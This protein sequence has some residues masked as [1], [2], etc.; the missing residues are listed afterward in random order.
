MQ[1]I[2]YFIL[3]IIIFGIIVYYNKKIIKITQEWKRVTQLQQEQKIEEI[4]ATEKEKIEMQVR[5][6]TKELLIQKEKI[7]EIIKDKTEY[8]E[9]LVGQIRSINDSLNE[10]RERA[11]VYEEQLRED[12]KQ[13][14]DLYE[15]DLMKLIETKASDY[16][17]EK[18]KIAEQVISERIAIMDMQADRAQARI[19]I[20]TKEIEEYSAKQ[21]AI[22]NAILRQRELEEQ[23]NFYRVCLSDEAIMDITELQI[24]R[25]KL[26]KPEIL[27]KIIYD[28]YVAKPVLEMVKRVLQNSTCSG[29]YKITCQETK[30]IYIG[31]STD[32]K[33][34]WQQHCKTAFNCGTIASSLLHRKMQQY[35]IEN[36]TFELLETVS[37]DK[38]SE[39]ES[40]Y[41]DFYQSKKVGLNERRG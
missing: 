26:K 19:E 5:H 22:N 39:R 9:S 34:R 32:I 27:D 28:T 13:R 36:F 14:T 11:K 25:Q 18:F 10:Q 8:V 17:Q 30:E 7:E 16:E 23:Q 3:L 21:A 12:A 40:F 1:Y 31:K 29:I 35:G 33:N 15:S 41:I 24:V 37:K 20:L 6:E 4:I 38:L 2:I